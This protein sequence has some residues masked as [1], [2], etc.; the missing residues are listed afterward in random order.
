M[1]VLK[2]FTCLKAG[3]YMHFNWPGIHVAG[4]AVCLEGVVLA[5]WERPPLYTRDVQPTPVIK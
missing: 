1:T 4:A 5:L 2:C 3:D